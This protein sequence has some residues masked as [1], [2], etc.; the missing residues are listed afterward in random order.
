MKN[1]LAGLIAISSLAAL[2]PHTASAADA[3]LAG[4]ITSAS[5]EKMGGVT[6]SAK[7]DGASV[8]TTVFS[9]TSGHYYFPPL[10]NG[11][12]RVW[13]QALSFATAKGAADLAA[14]SHQDFTLA[15]LAGDLIPKLERDT[16]QP[17]RQQHDNDRKIEGRQH[18]AICDGERREQRDTGHDEPGL[19]PIPG[20]QD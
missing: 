20:W 13:A 7:A 8:T 16:T 9:D 3:L 6:V 2:V 15:P 5:G 18:N 19:V 17:E 10:P 14:N 12:Y 4:T 11:H 1:A